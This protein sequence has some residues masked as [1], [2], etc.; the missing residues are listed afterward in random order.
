LKS[1]N[2]RRKKFHLL[3]DEPGIIPSGNIT[4]IIAFFLPFIVFVAVY[5]MKDIFPFGEECYLRSDMYHQYAPFYSELWNK[6]RSGETLTYSWDI[7]MGTN[8]ISLMAYYLASPV[9]WIIMLFPQKYMIEIMNALI[10]I[11]LSFASV[12]LAYYLT[13]HFNTKKCT[14]AVFSIFYALSGYVCAYSWNIMWLDCIV[15]LP[16]IMLGLE[17]LVKKNKGFLYCITLGLCIFTNY[18]ISIMVCISVAIYF[19]VLILSMDRLSSP[20]LYLKKILRWGFYSILAA[21]LAACFLLPEIYTFSLSASSSTTFP[22]SW[23]AYFSVVEM[24][25]RQLMY[26]PVHMGLEHYPNIFCGVAVFILI[27][28]YVCDREVKLTERIGKC[29]ILLIFLLSYN[30]NVFNYIW[31]GFHFPNSLPARQ[32]F[33][34]IFFV[35]TMSYEA[36]HH[37]KSI[38]D[39]AFGGSVWFALIFLVVASEIFKDS[40]TFTFKT[41]YI[42]GLF[43]LMYAALLFLEKR[44]KCFFPYPFII[45]LMLVV[46]ECSLNLNATGLGTTSRTSYL[47]DYDSV[48]DC[49]EEVEEEDSSFYRIDKVFGSRSKND[50]AWHNYK[51]ISTFSSTCNAGMSTFFTNLGLEASTN[52][53]GYNGSTLVTNSLFSVKYL[54]SNTELRTD[55]LFSYVTGSDGEYV[56]KNNYTLP[57]GYAIDHILDESATPSSVYNGI[58]NQDNLIEALTGV[59]NVF[60]L[61]YS[62]NSVTEA[63][64]VP[65]TNGHMYI[66]KP[67]NTTDFISV[68]INGVTTTFSSLKTDNRIL[69][70]GYVTTSD[71]V[72][73][74]GEPATSF[75][76]YILDEDKFLQAYNKLNSSAFL[77]GSY[78]TTSFT[79]TVTTSSHG[80]F[81]FSIPYDKGWSVYID[82]KKCTTYAA[83]DALLAVDLTAGTH[84]VKLKYT[85]VNYV[86][87]CIISVLCIII[88]I[89]IHL[90]RKFVYKEILED[91]DLPA[92]VIDLLNNE[93]V[94]TQRNHTEDVT[95]IE[96]TDMDDFENIVLEEEEYAD[97]TE[98]D[99]Q[100]SEEFK[101]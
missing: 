46:V 48:S 61:M 76:V 42:S 78:T 85:P 9:N 79:G 84:T 91:S 50:G 82:D 67:E 45:A 87:G 86:L 2:I 27:P 34:Y 36:F 100:E 94:V 101:K 68:T 65:T 21:G 35:L 77:I 57:V 93:D 14:V 13:E 31:H 20:V 53:Y 18:Y 30:L 59:S 28:M 25:T 96:L 62:Y 81:L 70:A 1:L 19:V 6:L 38:S 15:L 4:Y 58:Q 37:L 74:G 41:F 40:E 97:E 95:M 12:T 54:L 3:N 56:Y 92:I 23:T 10:I 32:A 52:A 73:V 88:L 26:V 55:K 7:G 24:L 83:F 8:F 99:I 11:K 5:Y 16:L 39:R 17:R 44:T 63:E 90:A 29:A 66:Y 22:Q 89:V 60:Q 43:M 98:S 47:A 49:L 72:T 71:V 75:K 51:T 80:T 33:I 64:F 69:D